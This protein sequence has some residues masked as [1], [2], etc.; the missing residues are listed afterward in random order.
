MDATEFCK[1]GPQS[2]ARLLAGRQKNARPG[3]WHG[4]RNAPRWPFPSTVELWLPGADGEDRYC[5][6]T[7]INLSTTGIGLK[8]DE[9]LAPGTEL[10]LAV[11]EP[12]M[13]FHGRAVVRHC[14]HTDHGF[15][16]AGL[17]FI[18]DEPVRGRVD[19]GSRAAGPL[20]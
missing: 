5:L 11:H 18:F 4:R 16:V 2:I 19:A 15:C 14:A 1:L 17:Q 6:A 9:P 10:S 13:S 7:S 12:E 8:V 3:H 20:L